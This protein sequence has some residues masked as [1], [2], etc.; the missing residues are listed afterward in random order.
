MKENEILSDIHRVR[1]EFA[2]ECGFDV[3]EIFRRMRER[4]EKLKAEGWKVASPKPRSEES[5]YALR[6]EPPKK[7]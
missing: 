4:T 5:S 7:S 1:E 3:N 6:E 2:R